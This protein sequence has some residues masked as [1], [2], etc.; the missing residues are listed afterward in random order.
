MSEKL[1]EFL[2]KIHSPK[3]NIPVYCSVIVRPGKKLLDIKIKKEDANIL[4][5]IAHEDK[6]PG[7][8]L[9]SVHIP[10]KNL[11]LSYNTKDKEILEYLSN[12]DKITSNNSTK[13]FIE[14]LLRKFI[15]I[16]PEKKRHFFRTER[17]KKKKEYRT[18]AQLKGF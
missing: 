9:H 4:R 15:D 14:Q 13:K 16:L 10:L 5:V 11:G 2:K 12:P 7:W 3:N 17:F 6:K 1:K 18:G 8:F